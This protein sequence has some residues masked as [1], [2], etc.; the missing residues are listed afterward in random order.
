MTI[1][2]RR[3]QEWLKS[4]S[5]VFPV[6]AVLVSGIS[7][8][9]QLSGVFPLE[10]VN[11][12]FWTA[13]FGLGCLYRP[14]WGFLLLLM[15][16]P[17]ETLNLLP[18]EW[19]FMLRPYQWLFVLLLVSLVIRVLS[20]R[21][22]WRLISIHPLDILLGLLP[23]GALIS[24]FL[25][26]GQG[27]RLAVI[28]C[29]F[30]ALYVLSRVFLKSTKDVVLAAT[31]FVAAGFPVLIYGMAQN[32]AFEFGGTLAS[33]MPGRPNGTFAEP[34][35]LGFFATILFILLFAR[36]FRS[37]SDLQSRTTGSLTQA[38]ALTSILV[39][40]ATTLIITVSR[41]AWLSLVVALGIAAGITLLQNGRQTLRAMFQTSELA[42]IAFIL[43]LFLAV[44]IPLTR[45]DLMNRAASTATGLQEI[46]I[47][48]DQNTNLPL[49]PVK[50]E[51]LEQ[52][53]DWR[54]QHI[55]LE[56]IE[57]E[58]QAGKMIATVYRVDPNVEI[59]GSI[60][61]QTWDEIRSHPVFGIGW[62]N[63]GAVLGQDENGS[64][65]NASNIWLEAWLGAGLI[66]LI[67]L[68]GFFVWCGYR[69]VAGLRKGPSY[70]GGAWYPVICALT[71]A[72]LVFNLFNAGLLIGLVWVWMAA[73]PVVLPRTTDRS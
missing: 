53:T 25:N 66:G 47:A 26:G 9:L 52:L 70:Q 72:F 40:V 21:T 16:L 7:I 24:G 1:S 22:P 30:Y 28:V 3:Y 68:L 34:D 23:L 51:N 46:T 29:S 15:L 41:S 17:F 44:E 13:L 12:I 54:C 20:G 73:L 5:I 36:L 56:S 61:R 37:I 63:I 42:V 65:Y 39:I 14:N 10:S 31:T 27:I 45:F 2:F 8:L 19:G 6:L 32:I 60:Y 38:L 69:I 49:P 4:P 55:M 33:V 57:T 64:S 67:G 18:I 59:R 35:W 58:K 43:A 11:L 50:I 71:A 48:C 62:G